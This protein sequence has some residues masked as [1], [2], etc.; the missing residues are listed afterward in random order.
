MAIPNSLKVLLKYYDRFCKEERLRIIEGHKTY[1]EDWKTKDNRFEHWQEILDEWGYSFLHD[2]Q[3]RYVKK[4][5]K[6][7]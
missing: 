4:K 7:K 1:K 2:A 3:K 5:K 6:L